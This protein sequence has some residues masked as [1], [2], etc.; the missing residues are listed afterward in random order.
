M[1]TQLHRLFESLTTEASLD[2]LVQ[3]KRE[4]DLYLEFKQ[5]A[6]TRNGD[7][8]ANDKK[9]FS[10]ALSGFANADGGILI[11][12]IG[13]KK[14]AEGVDRA[15]SLK[16]IKDHIR[17]RGHLMDSLLNATQP[18]VDDVRIE[19]IDA[20]ANSGYVKCLIPQSVKPPHRAILA[21]HHYWRR[22]STGNR[23]MEH[24]ELEDVFGRRLRPALKL[25]VELKPRPEGDPHE[26]LHFLLLNEGRGVARHVGLHCKLDVACKI[27]GVQ[28]NGLKN[29]TSYNNGQ[30]VVSYQDD[31]SVIHSNGIYLA[32]GSATILREI[33]GVPLEV[34]VT[35]YSE[36]MDTRRAEGTISPGNRYNLISESRV[37]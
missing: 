22:V 4:E 18:V 19:C 20:D 1:P 35:W 29:V 34:S 25:F 13:T 33:K 36:N 30:P 15:A 8:D 5:K 27:R 37:P 9:N 12:G 6:D 28:G 23:R 14:G 11:F 17:F 2:A 7:L 10:K 16:P 26:E 3:E 31:I 32:I 24:Y 21:D